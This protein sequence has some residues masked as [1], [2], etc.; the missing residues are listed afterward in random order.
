MSDVESKVIG[1]L[2]QIFVILR[3]RIIRSLRKHGIQVI[4]IDGGLGSQIIQFA[5][6]KWLRDNG[7]QVKL[8][9]SY[10]QHRSEK[11]ELN[12]VVQ[13]KWQLEKFGHDMESQDSGTGQRLRDVDFMHLYSDYLSE[14]VDNKIFL[15]SLYPLSHEQLVQSSESLQISIPELESSVII[16]IRQGD[17]LTAASLLLKEKYY[18]DAV[19]KIQDH[20]CEKAMNIIIVSDDEISKDRFP[21]IVSRLGFE[22]IEIR[23][24]IGGEALDVHNLMRKSGGL[25]C[26]NSTFSFSAA[27]LRGG[28]KCVY[29][30]RFYNGE[31]SALNRIFKLKSGIEI[32]IN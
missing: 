16:H 4:P 3:S 12:W 13:R 6:Y 11:S 32:P 24:V 18:L 1:K 25:I 8:D 22:N 23:T 5:L 31:T 30:S 9:T 17:Y 14:I 7:K 19:L 10:F 28:D 26:S 29:P 15:N 27:M 2:L 21:N 20:F